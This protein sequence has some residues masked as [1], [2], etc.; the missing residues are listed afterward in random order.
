[1]KDND[2]TK[3][4][5]IEELAEMRRRNSDLQKLESDRKKAEIS[6]SILADISDRTGIEYFQS[7]AAFIA[8][9]LG[10]EYVIIGKLDPYI[11]KVKTIAAYGHRKI[12]ENIEYDLH[13]TPCEHVIGKDACVYPD[14]IQQRFPDDILLVNMKAESYAG[15][16]LFAPDGQALGIIAT[17]GCSPIKMAE[18]DRYI[19]LLQIFSARVALELWRKD[20]E[21][22]FQKSK[23]ELEARVE[24]NTTKLES[25]VI[26]FQNEIAERK[27]SQ[28]AIRESEERFRTLV[29]QSPVSLQIMDPE[30]RTI[31]V[32]RA[33]EKLWGLT[34]DL[35]EGYNILQDKQLGITSYLKKAFS[36]EVVFIPAAEYDAEQTLGKGTKRWVQAHA[37]PVKNESGDITIVV[38]MHEDITD[39]KMAEKRIEASLKEKEVLMKEIHHRVKNNMTMISSLLSLQSNRVKDEHYKAMFDDSMNRIRT[40]AAIHERLY[41]FEDLSNIIFSDYIKNIVNSI[42]KSFGLSSR[43]KFVTDIEEISLAIDSSIPCGLIV[44]ELITNSMKYAFPDN[45]E[46]EIR[47][48]LHTNDTGEIKL[49]ISDN[50]VGMP[51]GL[52]FRNAESLGLDLVNALVEQL[53]GEIELS[54]EK[55]T[56]F[57]ITFKQIII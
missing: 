13:G 51:E 38:L 21:I 52:D 17:L 23:Q 16:P 54:R 32:N 25:T 37:Y 50:G 49:S 10:T 44:N 41:Q 33:W 57:M 46:G 24:E 2:K 20:M 36:G 26:L 28:I 55:G 14:K 39:R 43:I 18:K 48:S 30:G 4:Q 29:E 56:E 11:N 34:L 1:M 15:I 40:M 19:S 53:K 9:E 27:K 3:E 31:Q 35:L 42:F 5:L 7:I 47:V 6:L 22:S 8:R 45:R 12:I